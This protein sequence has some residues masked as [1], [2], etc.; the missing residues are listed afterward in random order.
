MID[1]NLVISVSFGK[2]QNNMNGYLKKNVMLCLICLTCVYSALILF[3]AFVLY[4]VLHIVM[5]IL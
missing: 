4:I 5:S 3:I 2:I 1:S